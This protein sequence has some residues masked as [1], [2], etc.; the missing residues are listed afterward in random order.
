MSTYKAMALVK[1]GA[2]LE[3]REY[4]MPTPTGK[5]VLL[6]VSHGGLCHSELHLQEGFFD[7]GDGNKMKMPD[8][9]EVVLGH[10]IEGHIQAVGSEVP[11]NFAVGKHFAVFPWIGCDV[12]TGPN[13]C[14]YCGPGLTQLCQDKDTKRF[15]DGNSKFGGY[16]SHVLVPD[17][18][19]LME[20]ESFLKPGLGAIY[21]CAG[22]TAF[23]ALKKVCT[24]P[25]GNDVIG[26][27]QQG[28][29]TRPHD[30]L[31]VGLGGLG[32]QA[33]NLAYGLLGD[34]PMVADINDVILEECRKKGCKHVFN[35]KDANG[36][37][38]AIRDAT[39]RGEG[40]YAALNF[41]G[42]E[43][44]ME[45]CKRVV[46]RSGQIVSV[47]L[48]GGK[49]QIPIPSL[50]LQT[51]Q[52]RGTMTGSHSEA[53]EMLN[54]VKDKNLP[55]PPYHYRNIREVNQAMDDLRNG[56]YLGRCILVHDWEGN[57]AS[58]M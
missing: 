33:V 18:K 12:T 24:T 52:I 2:P 3:E 25:G 38:K 7:V 16:G 17:Y 13:A 9:G 56:R 11:A 46:R 39:P 19:W 42:S 15:I 31:I 1:Y 21:M 44:T 53:Q 8:R 49:F 5:Q 45:F 27:T 43:Q 54:L 22:L 6:K 10:E 57:A 47:G 20:C 50:T 40:V 58:K 30:V 29:P 48:F 14:V 41:V 32:M 23:S 51:R 37:V 26:G 4:P 35:I 36:G 55:P 28:G 34:W